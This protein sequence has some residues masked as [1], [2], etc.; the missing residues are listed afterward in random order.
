MSDTVKIVIETTYLYVIIDD[1]LKGIGHCEHPGCECSDS[2]VITTAV[3]AALHF[4]G[5]HSY[6]IGFVQETGLMPPWSS[7]AASRGASTG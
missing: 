1:I 4:G 5:N 6:A 3:A 7:P 2:E